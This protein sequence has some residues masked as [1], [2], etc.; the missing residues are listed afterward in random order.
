MSKKKPVLT[1]DML[2]RLLIEA[3]T[4]YHILEKLKQ[5]APAQRYSALER[6][7]ANV[8]RELKNV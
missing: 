4:H 7:V 6:L 8:R 1:D 3:N 5:L 2:N